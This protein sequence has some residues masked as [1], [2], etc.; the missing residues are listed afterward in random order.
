[1]YTLQTCFHVTLSYTCAATLIAFN[2][3]YDNIRHLR[4]ADTPLVLVI[5]PLHNTATLRYYFGQYCHGGMPPL[6]LRRHATRCL[7]PLIRCRL[8]RDSLR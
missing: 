7:R 2:E 6:R 8:R 1:M 5:L 3:L 4:R